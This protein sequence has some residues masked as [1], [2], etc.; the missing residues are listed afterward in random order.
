MT[1]TTEPQL[2]AKS[3]TIRRQVV[4]D[5]VVYKFFII[6]EKG[7]LCHKLYTFIKKYII[8]TSASR[9]VYWFIPLLV[10]ERG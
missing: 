2:M 7:K 10:L 8:I 9:Y 1:F 5:F 4:G 6:C 3:P